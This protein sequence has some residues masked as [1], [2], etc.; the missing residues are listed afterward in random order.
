VDTGA[1]WDT[2]RVSAW[3]SYINDLLEDIASFIFLYADDANVFR[4]VDCEVDREALQK[5]LDQL[6]D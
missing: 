3:I 6:A 4:R 1:E 2:A 5:D